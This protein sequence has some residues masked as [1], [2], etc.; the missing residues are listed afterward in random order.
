MFVVKII[1]FSSSSGLKYKSHLLTWQ[2]NEKHL[3]LI[4]LSI[5]SDLKLE[6]SQSASF[7]LSFTYSK[8]KSWF[9]YVGELQML[10]GL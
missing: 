3:S 5:S 7:F 9:L 6:N 8:K 10:Y 4:Y 1:I 2:N